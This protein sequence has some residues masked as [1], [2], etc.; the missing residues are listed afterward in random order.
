M[1]R[2]ISRAAG[3][4]PNRSVKR[5]CACSQ[6]RS[7]TPDRKMPQEPTRWDKQALIPRA[8]PPCPMQVWRLGLVI[9]VIQCCV[10]NTQIVSRAH[11]KD[12]L[13]LCDLDRSMRHL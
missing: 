13:N 2:H 12:L 4:R 11:V 3:W 9:Y 8:C 6:Q 7:S 5:K 1:S 10:N